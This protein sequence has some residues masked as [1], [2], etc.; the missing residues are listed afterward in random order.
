VNASIHG[1]I[2]KNGRGNLITLFLRYGL[3][4]P[5][6]SK[7]QME[8]SKTTVSASIHSTLVPARAF[9]VFIDELVTALHQAGMDLEA[10]SNGRLV[11]DDFEVGRIVEWQPGELVTLHLDCASSGFCLS[12][13]RVSRRNGAWPLLDALT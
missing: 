11:Q 9:E 4:Q 12:S 7:E 8:E 1:I 10:G 3:W 5:K 6:A 2:A 13:V